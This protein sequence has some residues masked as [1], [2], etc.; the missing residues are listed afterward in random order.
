MS[1][2][3]PITDYF[4]V[5]FKDK[6]F[7]TNNTYLTVEANNQCQ[8]RSPLGFGKCCI[9]ITARDRVGNV[10]CISLSLESQHQLKVM[11]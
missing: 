4:S 11:F 10:H 5:I 8:P 1:P 7:M 9:P 3:S 6:V 2:F